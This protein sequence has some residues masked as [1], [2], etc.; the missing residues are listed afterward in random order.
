MKEE[1]NLA[2]IMREKNNTSKLFQVVAPR[3]NHEKES[4]GDWENFTFGKMKAKKIKR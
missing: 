3:H 4:R 2:L 1:S